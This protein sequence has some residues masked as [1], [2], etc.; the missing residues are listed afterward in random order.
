MTREF[1]WKENFLLKTFSASERLAKIRS[2]S[3]AVNSIEWTKY[4]WK[5]ERCLSYGF[6]QNSLKTRG[7]LI[8]SLFTNVRLGT[9]LGVGVSMRAIRDIVGRPFPVGVGERSELQPL[10]LFRAGGIRFHLLLGRSMGETPRYCR[11]TSPGFIYS[12]IFK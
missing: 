12:I 7:N 2:L 5:I 6:P 1:F 9:A 4:L 3:I 8:L 10:A 11:H